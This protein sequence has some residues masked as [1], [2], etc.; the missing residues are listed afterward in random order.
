MIKHFLIIYL[1]AFF[2]T[3][4]QK[5]QEFTI[6]TPSGYPTLHIFTE[7]EKEVEKE[8]Y[9]PAQYVFSENAQA[10]EV[11]WEAN[12]KIKGRGNSTWGMPKR[13]YK[14]KFDKKQA[15]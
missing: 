3:A 8:D 9:V 1:L 13:P 11:L 15:F 2:L 12:G 10:E 14:I 6:E 4:C 7:N 5:T